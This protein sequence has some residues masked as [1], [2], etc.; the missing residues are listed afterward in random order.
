MEYKADI[1]K[2]YLQKYI[3]GCEFR[4]GVKAWFIT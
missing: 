2:L 4:V 1:N 3:E